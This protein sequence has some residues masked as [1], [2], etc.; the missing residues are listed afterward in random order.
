MKESLEAQKQAMAAEFNQ[1]VQRLQ[2]EHLSELER[3]RSEQLERMA[4]LR[5]EA[6]EVRA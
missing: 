5:Q 4:K 6:D 3:Q 2:D 1:K